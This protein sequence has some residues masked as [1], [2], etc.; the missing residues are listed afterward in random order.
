MIK[1]FRDWLLGRKD[2]R[3]GAEGAKS[4]VHA[5]LDDAPCNQGCYS[6][7]PVFLS[8]QHMIFPNMC[9]DGH[10]EIGHRQPDDEMCPMCLA[11]Q[12]EAQATLA[13]LDLDEE[14]TDIEQAASALILKLDA[15]AFGLTAVAQ[16]A[17]IHGM[18]YDGPTYGAELEALRD[19]VSPN[20]PTNDSL[21]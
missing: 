17:A 15:A 6:Y 13:V 12:T 5:H 20:R 19:I 18:P 1:F 10:V 16:V 3:I 8:N 9:R 21:L 14:L 4:M 11:T 2:I 7:D